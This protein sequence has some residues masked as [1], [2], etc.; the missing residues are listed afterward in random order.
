LELWQINITENRSVLH[1][2][3]RAARDTI[4]NCDGK[5][6]VDDVWK[7][8]DKISEFSERVRTGAWVS[9]VRF[10]ITYH[11]SGKVLAVTQFQFVTYILNKKEIGR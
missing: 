2:A 10:I 9:I 8:L 4:I 11:F 7:V 1:I 5:N 6:V 3:L